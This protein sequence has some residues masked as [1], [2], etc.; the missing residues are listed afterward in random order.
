MR[1]TALLGALLLGGTMAAQAAPK[2]TATIETSMGTIVVELFPDQ[3][4]NTVANFVGLATGAKE[5]VDPKTGQP[6]NV[7]G[8]FGFGGD[9]LERKTS[10][11]VNPGIPKTPGMQ[12]GVTGSSHVD[13]FHVI[14]QRQSNDKR[15]VFVSNVNDFFMDF[16]TNYGVNLPTESVTYGNEWDLYSASMSETSAQVK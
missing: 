7:C 9:Y 14:A 15:Q 12:Q 11:P 4:P 2:Q 13:H 6:Y 1:R 8:A 16:E 10:A 3:S 5:Y